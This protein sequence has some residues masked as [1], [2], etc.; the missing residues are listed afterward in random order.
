EITPELSNLIAPSL[1]QIARYEK[2]PEDEEAYVDQSGLRFPLDGDLS[3]LNGDL[4]IALGQA[5]FQ[6]SSA[7]ARLLKTVQ[8]ESQAMVGRRLEPLVVK[9]RDGVVTYDRFQIPLGEFNLETSGTVDL[10]ARRLDVVTWIPIGALTDEAAGMFNT[11]LGSLLGRAV[12]EF[13]RLTMAPWRTR[14]TFGNTQTLPAP[15]MFV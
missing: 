1:P 10:P 3:K 15:G 7:F 8:A 9:M 14:G 12:P 5:P 2:R 11:G 4:T 13:E 6:T